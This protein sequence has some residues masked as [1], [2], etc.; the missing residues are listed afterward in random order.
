MKPL[1][2]KPERIAY[3]RHLVEGGPGDSTEGLQPLLAGLMAETAGS[4]PSFDRLQLRDLEKRARRKGG[5]H[6]LLANRLSR[7]DRLE[8][9][10]VPSASAF[11]FLLARHGKPRASVAAEI[12]KAWQG[13]FDGFDPPSFQDL[14]H[15]ITEAYGDAKAGERWVALASALAGGR[16]SN[17]VDLLLEQNA[18]VMRSRHAA[19]PWVR[20]R[21]GKLDVRFRDES[22]DSGRRPAG[23]VVAQQLLPRPAQG[24]D[25]GA[26]G[27]PV[28]TQ[29]P[30]A[31]LSERLQ[32]LLDS[33]CVRTAVFLTYRFDPGFFEQEVLPTLFD[34]ALSHEP[35]VRLIQLEEELRKS[36]D[37][38]AVYYD[39]GA[40]EPGA[41]SAK[42]DIREFHPLAHGLLSSQGRPPPRGETDRRVCWR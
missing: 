36:V 42:L 22:T 28:S 32:E 31:V 20:I 1:F 35:N 41:E 24:H 15:E 30:R 38:M 2:T 9:L 12:G 19:E 5:K 4:D 23:H 3:W 10:L 39:F 7:I 8:S 16:W 6:E 13:A 29:I 33:R 21:D 18:F 34:R 26:R 37:E 27:S 25:R 17:F 11:G 40:L 14:A